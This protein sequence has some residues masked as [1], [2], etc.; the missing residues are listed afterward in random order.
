MYFVNQLKMRLASL[1]ITW[2]KFYL[3]FLK[4]N[5]PESNYIHLF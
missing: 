2:I 3:I 1:K 4:P 5:Q